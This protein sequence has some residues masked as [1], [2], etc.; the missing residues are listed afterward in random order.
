MKAQLDIYSSNELINFFSNFQGSFI[1]NNKNHEDLKKDTDKKNLSIVLLEKGNK[2]PR[3]ILEEI[4]KNEN[5][6]FVC[7]DSSCYENLNLNLNQKNLLVCPTSVNRLID[8]INS[9]INLKKHVFS[10][11]ELKNYVITN[12]NTKQKIH[13]TQVEN[14]ILTK[15]FIEKSFEKRVLERDVLQIKQ[16]L[17]TSSTESHLN[18]IRKKLKQINSNFTISSK[19]K[20]IYLEVI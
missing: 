7:E 19:E 17:N 2:T 5:Y 10:Y 18:R 15:L 1:I 9:F 14:H 20:H 3:E 4:S 8:L 13:L 12:L 11:I 16:D 6:I